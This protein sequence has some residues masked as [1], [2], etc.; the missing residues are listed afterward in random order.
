MTA[1]APDDWRITNQEKH[2]RGAVLTFRRYRQPRPDW[3]HEHCAFCFAKFMESAP[4]GDLRLPLA[5]RVGQRAS[6]ICG[7]VDIDGDGAL[8][9][10]IGTAGPPGFA[11]LSLGLDGR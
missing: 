1:A 7:N 4:P 11:R 8:D 6:M 9:V 5:F 10:L 3:D 2:L